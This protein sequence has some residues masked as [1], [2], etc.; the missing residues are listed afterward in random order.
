MREGKIQSLKPLNCKKVLE[1]GSEL[2]KIVRIGIFY[3]C[4]L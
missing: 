4:C 2:L 3:S 1:N